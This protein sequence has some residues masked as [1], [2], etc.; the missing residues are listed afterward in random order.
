MLF[1]FSLHMISIA[2]Q[3]AVAVAVQDAVAAV[4][5]QFP[6]TSQFPQLKRAL[7]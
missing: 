3:D 1:L 6:Y 4:C 5:T 2:V 7:D